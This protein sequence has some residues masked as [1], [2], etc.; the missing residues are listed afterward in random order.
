MNKIYK[1]LLIVIFSLSVLT[2][3]GDPCT[4]CGDRS[5]GGQIMN[6]NNPSQSF[7]HFIEQF[8]TTK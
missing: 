8:D 1:T 6:Q 3:C 7:W 4:S 5:S 2:G